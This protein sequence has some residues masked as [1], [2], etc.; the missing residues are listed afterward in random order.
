VA[1]RPSTICTVSL[2]YRTTL[3]AGD[4]NDMNDGDGNECWLRR[5]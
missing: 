4:G 2:P 3:P 5:I 1:L